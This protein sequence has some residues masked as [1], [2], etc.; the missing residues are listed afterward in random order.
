M[1]VDSVEQLQTEVEN[2]KQCSIDTENNINI[3]S[4]SI[5]L[6][7]EQQNEIG[8]L[9]EE[10]SRKIQDL[11][12]AQNFLTNLLENTNK[13][14]VDSSQIAVDMSDMAKGITLTLDEFSV[15]TRGM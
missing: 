1:A 9:I 7:V 4:Q 11:K 10:Q 6:T 15:S 14:I 8:A 2:S 5:E 3:I 12:V 13:K